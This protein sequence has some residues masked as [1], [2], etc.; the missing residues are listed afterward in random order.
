MIWKLSSRVPS[1]TRWGLVKEE[2]KIYDIFQIMQDTISEGWYRSPLPK[3]IVS[4]WGA[5]ATF[6]CRRHWEALGRHGRLSPLLTCPRA[7]APPI[8][9]PPTPPEIHCQPP[10]HPPYLRTLLQS[11]TLCLLFG[12]VGILKA[13]PALALLLPLETNWKQFEAMFVS[14]LLQLLNLRFSLTVH[15]WFLLGRY[16]NFDVFAVLGTRTI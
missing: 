4:L 8:T 5:A 16:F 14:L 15:F 11:P 2:L 1:S 9:A 12:I 7:E 3:S 6:F 10:L 13:S